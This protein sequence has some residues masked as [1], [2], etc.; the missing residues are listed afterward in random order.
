M[1]EELLP[2]SKKRL[3]ELE[4]KELWLSALQCAGVDNWEGCE[5]AEE[6]LH[7]WEQE[8]EQ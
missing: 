5:Y 4:E 7:E 3:Q 6:L 2:V 1:E 8:P